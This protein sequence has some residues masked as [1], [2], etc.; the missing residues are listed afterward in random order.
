[1][2]DAYATRAEEDAHWMRCALDEAR[3]ALAAGEVPVGAVIVADGAV[4]ARARNAMIAERDRRRTPRSARC[5]RRSRRR[6][7]AT[8]RGHAVS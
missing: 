4:R 6:R 7:R 1:V 3:T 5:A 8:R 2:T